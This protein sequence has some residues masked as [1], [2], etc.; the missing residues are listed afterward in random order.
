[1]FRLLLEAGADPHAA[2]AR[3]AGNGNEPFCEIA[4][5]HG[6][7][8]DRATAGGQP[9]L[10]HLIRWGRI[11]SAVWLLDRG[12]SPNIADDRGWTAIHQAASRGNERIMRAVLASGGDRKIRDCAGMTPA[13]IAQVMR[14]PTMKAQLAGG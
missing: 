5:A 4:L 3:A 9:L 13:D 14:R 8:P 1:M 6:A 12:A 2:L 10:N 7:I 11:D